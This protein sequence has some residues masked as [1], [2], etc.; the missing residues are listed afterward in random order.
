MAFYTHTHYFVR[1]ICKFILATR[2]YFFKANI[3][4]R[5]HS[6]LCAF[7]TLGAIHII[8]VTLF[9]MMRNISPTIKQFTGNNTSETYHFVGWKFCGIWKRKVSTHTECKRA[10]NWENIFI[11]RS[12]FAY[13]TTLMESF[14]SFKKFF[15]FLSNLFVIQMKNSTESFQFVFQWFHQK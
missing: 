1:C 5:A 12:S 3:V 10:F 13:Y 7:F 9:Q 2:P 8:C 4:L 11:K 14:V 6:F 15:N